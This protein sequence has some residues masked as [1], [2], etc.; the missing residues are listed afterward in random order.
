MDDAH[1]HQTGVH[2]RARIRVGSGLLILSLVLAGACDTSPT[3]PGDTVDAAA[4]AAAVQEVWTDLPSSSD[5]EAEAWVAVEAETVSGDAALAILDAGELATE[6]ALALDLGEDADADRLGDAADALALKGYLAALGPATADRVL[7]G[8]LAARAHLRQRFGANVG[9]DLAAYLAE[10]DAELEMALDARAESDHAGVLY[11]AGRASDAMR[12][13][14]PQ[15]KAE[16]AVAR[17]T[18]LLDYAIRLAGDDPEDPIARALNAA[19]QFCTA[20]GAALERELWRVA[21]IEARA[22]ARLSRAVI[23]RLG[24]GIDEDVLAERAEQAVDHASALLER[25]IE[26]AGDDASAR[27]EGLLADAEALLERSRVALEEARFR[28]AIGLA[29]ESS[30]RSLRVIRLLSDHDGSAVELRA[31][32]AVEVALAMEARVD[33][34][35]T[36]ATSPEIIEA[37]ARADALVRE[38]EAALEAGSYRE[39]WANARAAVSIYVRILLALA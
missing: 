4:Q 9:G 12:W 20:A 22:C 23:V 27:I 6:S 32:A 19:G 39:A 7:D 1:R 11:H 2:S 8:V 38:A 18:V 33:E 16:A 31:S 10:A 26:M 30:A 14:D 25:A 37:D 24:G 17:A 36:D 34:Q 13:L 35:I 5:L 3:D 29:I 15:A 28:A 21:V